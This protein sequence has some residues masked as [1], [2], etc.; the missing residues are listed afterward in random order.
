MSP[1]SRQGRRLRSDGVF[2]N[3]FKWLSFRQLFIL[4]SHVKLS[5]ETGQK[6]AFSKRLKND[7]LM[8]FFTDTMYFR[9]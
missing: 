1:G 6:A 9:N 4:F 2:E 5:W 8:Y 3:E 7:F